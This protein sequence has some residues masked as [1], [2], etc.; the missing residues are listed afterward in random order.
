[1][2]VTVFVNALGQEIYVSNI[3]VDNLGAEQ[4]L[5]DYLLDVTAVNR[6]IFTTIPPTTPGTVGDG[7]ITSRIFLLDPPTTTYVLENNT[8]FEL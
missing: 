6:L 2:S 7:T 5:D 1:M 3:L 4:T 8:V